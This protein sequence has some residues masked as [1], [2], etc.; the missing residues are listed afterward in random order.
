[1]D[2]K[3]LDRTVT[4]VSDLSMSS[5]KEVIR[6]NKEVLSDLNER[7]GPI[8]SERPKWNG[9]DHRMFN[10]LIKMNEEVR[11]LLRNPWR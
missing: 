4:I 5:N 3:Q 10:D 11:S 2:G 1:M 6:M 7:W 8:I 9:K